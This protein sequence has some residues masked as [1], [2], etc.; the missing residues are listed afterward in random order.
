MA[1]SIALLL[2][3]FID[4]L[5]VGIFKE[6][7]EMVILA[8]SVFVHKIPVGFTL[9]FLFEQ[10]GYKLDTWFARIILALFVISTPIGVILGAVISNM[11]ELV[12]AII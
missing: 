7:E 2:H 5:A 1:F 6:V 12:L 9:G 3:S 10:S 11:S 8:I 4:G